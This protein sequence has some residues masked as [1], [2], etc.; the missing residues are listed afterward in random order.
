MSSPPRPLRPLTALL[1]LLLLLLPGLAA[2]RGALQEP[3]RTLPESWVD[4]MTWRSIGPSNMGGRITD[5]AVHPTDS[6]T[7]WIATASGGI[8]KTTNG[9]VTWEH[10]FDR[11]ATV[12]IGDVTVA[13]SDPSVVWVGTGEANP[14]N[15]VSWGNGVYKSTDGGASWKHMGL[16]ES[17]Q[18]G[19]ILIHPADANVVYVGALGRLWGP[20]EER[21]LY[22]TSDGG[23]SWSKVLDLGPETGVVDMR[24]KPDDPETLLVASYERQRDGFDTNDPAKKW[25]EGSGIWRTTDGGASWTEVREGLPSGKLGRIG[26]D[27]YP[28]D[29][30]VVFAVVESERITQEPE[31]AAFFGV[32]SQDAEVGARLTTVTAESPAAAAGLEVGDIVLRVEDQLVHSAADL[33]REIRKRLAGETVAMQVSRERKTVDVEVS[34]TARPESKEDEA[35]G[36]GQPEPRRGQVS[37]DLRDDSPEPGPFHIGL[38]GQRENA[39]DEQGPDGHEYGG[40][41]RS[42]DAGLTWKRINSL[43][44]RP[45]Y[46]S[47][48]RVDPSSDQYLYVLGTQLYRSSD[49]GATFTDD[50]HDGAVH[51]DHHALWIDPAD[52]R[53]MILGNDGGIY[54]TWDRMENWDHHNQVA[55]GQFYRVEVGPR[56]DYRVYGGLQDNGSWGGPSRSASGSGPINADWFRIGGGDGFVVRV[57]REDPD[58][59]YMESQNGAMGSM[60]L[61]TGARGSARPRAPRGERYR[62]NWNTP[63]LLSAHNSR[64]HYS[65]GNKVFRSLDRGSNPQA[66]SPEIT[67]TDR[68]SATALSESARDSDV[69][70]VGSDDGGLWGTTDGGHTWTDLW[71][72]TAEA[73][74]ADAPAEAVPAAA[75]G[76]EAPAAA[77]TAPA[78]PAAELPERFREFDANGDGKLQAAELPERMAGFVDRLD[79]DGDGVVTG[80]EFAAM[81]G[82]G[83]PGGP[84]GR[85][86]GRGERGERPAPPAPEPAPAQDPAPAAPAA[87]AERDALTGAWTALGEAEGLPEGEGGFTLNLKLDGEAVSGNLDSQMGVAEIESGSFVDGAL[88]FTAKS[89]LGTMNGSGTVEGDRM[90]GT[91]SFGDGAFEL[92]FSAERPPAPAAAPAPAAEGEATAPT[93]PQ[94]IATLMPGRR[95]VS[96]VAASRHVDGRV[97]VTF[98]GHRSDD[99]TP[100]LFV[101]EDHGHTWTSLRGNLPDAAGTTRALVEDLENPDLLFLGTEF[102]AWA[103]ID[104]GAS[105]TSLHSNLPTVAVHDFAIHPLRHELVAATHGRSLWILDIL[106]LRQLAGRGADAPALLAPN[107]VVMWRR[108]PERGT[109]VRE[110]VG[111]NPAEGARIHYV[112]PRRARSAELWI[113]DLSG[114]R[115]RELE[116]ASEPGLHRADWD[117]RL[118]PEA[119]GRRR[120]ARRVQ[121]GTY[122]AVLQLDGTTWRQPFEVDL[123][124]NFP[125]ATW[126]EVEQSGEDFLEVEEEGAAPAAPRRIF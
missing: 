63:F 65:A 34:F 51:V 32:E 61:R 49:G 100:Y 96:S 77:P 93:G 19:R 105:W 20:N 89:E 112:V 76:G 42:D 5:I 73:A 120:W 90:T 16:A 87:P 103:S 108:Q 23:E 79:A 14:R 83:G 53:H 28:Q 46:Y 55:I 48:V 70:Y 3:A 15:S 50:G 8:V 11:E 78:A 74:P 106:P 82:R 54:E 17:F 101:S 38:G 57:D 118:T 94:P 6:R 91:I 113:E 29:P 27:W 45:M 30:D 123:D 56:M 36:E 37:D 98:D 60:N 110:F 4:A 102:G 25:G 66:I 116:A 81:R 40:I 35:E 52:G 88:N 44:P 64:I 68:G 47:E 84:G 111:E 117:L 18:T 97:Y 114:E 85:E 59:L 124:P 72:V 10:Q 33:T 86:G 75:E 24:F 22:K 62:F 7:I 26:L 126:F 80:E 41:Y 13:P 99:D 2:Q 92:G 1:A 39:Q 95:W 122:V 31:D 109:T 67:A 69:L 12:S 58:Q 71:A 125:D 115:V 9:G 21:G 119:G 104:R 43:N 121:P 107:D